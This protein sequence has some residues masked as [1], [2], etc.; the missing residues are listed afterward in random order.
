MAKETI[1][2]VR[3]AELNAAQVEKDA[4]LKKER[5]ISEAMQNAK[6][7]ISSMTN[8][9]MKLSEEKVADANKK[10]ILI[11]E[12]AKQKSDAQVTQME[13]IVKEKEH[14]AMEQVLSGII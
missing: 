9:A 6:T 4:Q 13:R 3:Q 14:A 11:M 8:E 12:E 10:R 1:Q 7:M 2:A 5:I